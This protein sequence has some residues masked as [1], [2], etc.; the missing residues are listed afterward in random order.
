MGARRPV[1][2][3]LLF[4]FMVALWR[5]YLDAREIRHRIAATTAA[6]LG[7]GGGSGFDRVFG[8]D[9]RVPNADPTPAV[10]E[11]SFASSD[12]TRPKEL[13]NRQTTPKPKSSTKS[14]RIA[15]AV[16]LPA[17]RAVRLS[18]PDP[19]AKP[20]RPGCEPK[21]PDPSAPCQPPSL[22]LF[23]ES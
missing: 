11:A 21:P 13:R 4:G 12:R 10:T 14:S 5:N 6:D 7:A 19:F 2:M 20:L 15:S 9:D 16:T 8:T 18:Y 22:C 1:A 17:V 3:G 23:T